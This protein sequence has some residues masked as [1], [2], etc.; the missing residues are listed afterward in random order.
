[1]LAALVALAALW[2]Y[3]RLAVL[4]GRDRVIL[5]AV[6]TALFGLALFADR[7]PDRS[8]EIW[9]TPYY[10]APDGDA[11]PIAFPTGQ[12]DRESFPFAL[13]GKLVERAWRQP[14]WHV[15]G[16]PHPFGHDDLRAAIAFV[17]QETFLFSTTLEDNIAFGLKMAGE[18]KEEIDARGKLR[19]HPERMASR[20]S[21]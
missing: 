13:W 21:K 17:P 10:V 20:S 5:L 3:Q 4:R 9:A 16:T 15:A 6:R 18:S 19:H 12:P 11:A 2:T 8:A 7:G 1:M 14:S